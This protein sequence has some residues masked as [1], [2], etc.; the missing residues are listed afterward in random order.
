MVQILVPEQI[1]TAET[2]TDNNPTIMKKI[3]I[4]AFA[5][6]TTGLASSCTKD[7]SV[8]PAKAKTTVV[9]DKSELGQG[10]FSDP[11]NGTGSTTG[12]GDG[13]N[14]GTGTDTNGGN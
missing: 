11:D 8:A 7:N 14:T 6:I 1:L 4:I 3:I 10:D 5:I 12:T 9:A 13:S 2:N